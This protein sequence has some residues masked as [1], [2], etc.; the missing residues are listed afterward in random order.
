MVEKARY[1]FWN[2]LWVFGMLGL[3]VYLCYLVLEWLL[4]GNGQGVLVLGSFA[5]VIYFVFGWL[6]AWLSK[7]SGHPRWKVERRLSLFLLFGA[8]VWLG[9]CFIPDQMIHL[10]LHWYWRVLLGVGVGW[11]G[12]VTRRYT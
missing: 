1:S 11:L 6:P 9:C 2:S 12:L 5:F 10:N 4:V 7:R 8:G 3:L